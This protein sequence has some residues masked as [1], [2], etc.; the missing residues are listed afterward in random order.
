MDLRDVEYHRARPTIDAAVSKAARKYGYDSQE[1]L[2]ELRSLADLTYAEAQYYYRPVGTTFEN[3][4]KYLLKR[5][6]ADLARKRGRR[7]R[8][9]KR[10]LVVLDTLPAPDTRHWSDD[11]S[12]DATKVVKLAAATRCGL[13]PR[14]AGRRIK[15]YLLEIGYT[16]KQIVACWNEIREALLNP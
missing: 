11:L 6:L 3:Y 1:E 12:E 8:I 15:D 10:E 7:N 5:R 4:L 9:I 14:Q 16:A 2:A 13:D